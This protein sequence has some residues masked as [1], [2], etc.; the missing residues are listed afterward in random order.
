MLTSCRSNRL[1]SGTCLREHFHTGHMRSAADPADRVGPRAAIDDGHQIGQ[2]VF[3]D[4]EIIAI[5]PID[6]IDSFACKEVIA[7][8][9]AKE[10]IVVA[11][12]R[13]HEARVNLVLRSPL[14][15]I[16]GTEPV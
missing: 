9:V 4:E 1:Y 12:G 5:A 6:R 13:N 11:V 14:T 7:A 16:A 15:F 8:G 3:N 10:L 2:I